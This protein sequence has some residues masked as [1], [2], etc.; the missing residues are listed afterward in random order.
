MYGNSV[1]IGE[2]VFEN[3]YWRLR[4]VPSRFQQV[5]AEAVPK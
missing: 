2:W 1:K 4:I 5:L 3:N